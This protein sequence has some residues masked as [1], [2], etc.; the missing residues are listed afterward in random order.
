M[1]SFQRIPTQSCRS[2][3]HSLSASKSQQADREQAERKKQSKQS[4]DCCDTQKLD[5]ETQDKSE[6]VT[7]VTRVTKLIPVQAYKEQTESKSRRKASQLPPNY[8]LKMAGC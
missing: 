1:V 5:G 4:Y 6:R 3:A 7:S 2:S 8:F